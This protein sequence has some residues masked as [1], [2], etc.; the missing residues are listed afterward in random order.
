M[1]TLLLF[2]I[3]PQKRAALQVIAL[4]CGCRLQAV[5]TERHG[6][7]LA[8]ILSGEEGAAAPE[9]PFTEELLVLAGVNQRQLDTVLSELRRR[10]AHIPL[11][12][13]LTPTNAAW[14]PGELYAELCAEREAIRQGGQAHGE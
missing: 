4:R 9:E 10:K 14:T 6:A 11:K 12:A 7:T 8:Q 2:N 1:P 13:V 5:P 3:A